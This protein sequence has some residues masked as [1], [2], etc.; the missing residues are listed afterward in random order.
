MPK[1]RDVDLSRWRLQ[2]RGV[3]LVQQGL[4]LGVWYRR[5]H[6]WQGGEVVQRV[7]QHLRRP[8]RARKGKMLH[9]VGKPVVDT[10]LLHLLGVG[11]S[12]VRIDT[13]LLLLLH[14][15]QGCTVR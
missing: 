5:V 11:C 1:L 7:R 15:R 14:V 4:L 6:D 13:L 12:G 9:V 8:Q 2:P 3:Q 10:A